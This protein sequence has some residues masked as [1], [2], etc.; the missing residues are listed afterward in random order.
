MLEMKKKAGRKPMITKERATEFR[1]LHWKGY[2]MDSIA[3]H[4]NVSNACVSL[5]IKKL[6]EGGFDK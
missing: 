6:R 1:D 2:S 4:F 5:S 3:K